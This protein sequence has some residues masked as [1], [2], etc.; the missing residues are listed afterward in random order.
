MYFFAYKL[1][2][3]EGH[4]WQHKISWLSPFHYTNYMTSQKVIWKDTKR[5]Q[6]C[7]SCSQRYIFGKL[8]HMLVQDFFSNW[9]LFHLC[10][11]LC[12]ESWYSCLDKPSQKTQLMIWINYHTNWFFSGL[13]FHAFSEKFLMISTVSWPR[14][15]ALNRTYFQYFDL[16]WFTRTNWESCHLVV[17]QI[18]G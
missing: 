16:G 8:W 18:V 3:N 2:Y 1:L 14:G 6:K 11:F 12:F 17:M 4:L 9:Y 7:Y 15:I 10:Q 5:W 13:P